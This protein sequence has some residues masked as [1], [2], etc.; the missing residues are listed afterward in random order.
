MLILLRRDP[1]TGKQNIIVKLESDPDSLPIEHEQLHRQLVEKLIGQGIDAESLGEVV[2]ERD[3]VVAP[4]TAKA[5]QPPTE[6]QGQA[7]SQGH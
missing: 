7:E 4:G 1:D 2:I 3:Q 5:D 6:D